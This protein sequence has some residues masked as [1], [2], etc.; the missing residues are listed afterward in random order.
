M[1]LFLWGY[2]IQFLVQ[3][4]CVHMGMLILAKEFALFNMV[5]NLLLRSCRAIILEN[6]GV[7]VVCIDFV[8]FKTYLGYLEIR[9]EE[10]QLFIFWRTKTTSYFL[11]GFYFQTPVLFLYYLFCFCCLSLA[12]SV[13][14]VCVVCQC[15]LASACRQGTAGVLVV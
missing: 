14:N 8:L 2:P 13:V 4:I 11:V 15:V 1:K 10:D 9:D 12:R 7:T 5:Y 3:F 6:L